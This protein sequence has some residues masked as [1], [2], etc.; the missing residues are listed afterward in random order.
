M[1]FHSKLLKYTFLFFFIFIFIFFKYT[2]LK[3]F[4]K[5]TCFSS[6]KV[7]NHEIMPSG[8]ITKSVPFSFA[9]TFP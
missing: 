8:I 9:S 6:S 3:W 5:K 4:Y 1:I 2:F 7:R